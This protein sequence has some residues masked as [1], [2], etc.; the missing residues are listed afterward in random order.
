MPEPP[1]ILVPTSSPAKILE[2]FE[3]IRER[4]R[5]G[6]IDPLT[7][8]QLLKFFQFRDE[9]GS[10][11]TPGARTNKWYRREGAR[12]VEKTPPALLLLPQLPVDFAPETEPPPLPKV[13]TSSAKSGVRICPTCGSSNTGKKFCTQCG[14]RLT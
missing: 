5:M 6:L 8:N 13:E 1:E 3:E 14:T 7:F 4:Y 11:W 12:W 10:L 9:A 2:R